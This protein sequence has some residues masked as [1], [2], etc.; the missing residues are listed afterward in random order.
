M[1]DISTDVSFADLKKIE[2]ENIKVLSQENQF[3]CVA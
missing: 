3:Y 1:D 2:E